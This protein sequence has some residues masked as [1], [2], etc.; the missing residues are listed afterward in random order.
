[1]E[2]NLQ[3]QGSVRLRARLALSFSVMTSLAIGITILIL[4]VNFRAELR[5]QLRLRA[6]NLA[7]AAALQQNGDEFEQIKSGQDPLHEKFRIQNLKIRRVDPDIEYVFTATKDKDG[8]YFVVDAGEPGEE[9]I[10]QYGER[11]EEPSELLWEN[12]DTMTGA[13]ADADI[14]TD[15]YG[16]FISSYA[17]IF[18]SDGRRVGV[19]GLDFTVT[20]VIAKERQFLWL[21]L[22][23]FLSTLP[24]VILFGLVL[25]SRLAAPI[26]A[27]ADVAGEF[28]AGGKSQRAQIKSR[29]IE[30]A[31]L[32]KDFNMMTDT[33]SDL[34]EGLEKRVVERTAFAEK[35][36]LEAEL[37]RQEAEAQAWFARGQAQLAEIMRGELDISTLANNVTSFLSQYLGAHSGALFMVSGDVLKLTGHYA[38]MGRKNRKDEF[39]LDENLI[40]E[41]ARSTR[42]IKL[43]SIPKDAPLIASSLGSAKPNQILIAPIGSEEKALGVLEFSTLDEFS[44]EHENFLRRV[45]ESI[46]IAFRT[47]QTRI[48]MNELLAQSQQQAEELQAQEEELRAA[49]EE[50]HA[51]A[52]RLRAQQ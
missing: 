25:G 33:V 40:G 8:L 45:S 9:N 51:Q 1:M 11:Y 14:Y 36:R 44:A 15:D 19:I 13:I 12:Y 10:A 18:T 39:R 5:Q 3:P 47:A 35:A 21:S 29:V 16:S 20:T 2:S 24:F 27:L 23:V 43:M 46:A 41:A 48:R 28:A 34:I 52:E 37:A 17:P 4:Y 38:C 32:V 42:V 49:N 50:L 7:A 6:I 30:I 26:S 31:E 22:G